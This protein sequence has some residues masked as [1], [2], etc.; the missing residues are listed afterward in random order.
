VYEYHPFSIA[1]ANHQSNNL[2]YVKVIP[3][4]PSE[5]ERESDDQERERQ[6]T[7]GVNKKKVHMD[8][9]TWTEKLKKL[10][11]TV[12]SGDKGVGE[13]IVE[14]SVEGPYGS[15]SVDLM[16]HDKY[17]VSLVSCLLIILYM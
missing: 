16:D 15:L 2:F 12:D 9:M 1:S 8:E 4:C 3:S 10:C 14:M 5:R 17:P 11:L 7:L 13:G 6:R